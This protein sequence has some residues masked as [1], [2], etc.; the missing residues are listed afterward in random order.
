MRIQNFGQPEAQ[1][2]FAASST[3]V[4]SEELKQVDIWL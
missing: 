2:I 3:K 1:N 4:S